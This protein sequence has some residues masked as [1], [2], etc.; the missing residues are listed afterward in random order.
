MIKTKKKKLKLHA[1]HLCIQHIYHPLQKRCY[2]HHKPLFL[3]SIIRAN[4]MLHIDMES[5]LC[6]LLMQKSNSF[7]YLQSIYW[8]K[9]YNQDLGPQ[10]IL[11]WILPGS[12]GLRSSCFGF[13]CGHAQGTPRRRRRQA[14]CPLLK[15][16]GKNHLQGSKYSFNR[17][18]SFDNPTCKFFCIIHFE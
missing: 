13:A 10:V 6:C 1:S 4:F 5:P 11:L 18:L 7:W 14:P 12:S 2:E 3:S 17:F 8:P 16:T 9:C 15:M